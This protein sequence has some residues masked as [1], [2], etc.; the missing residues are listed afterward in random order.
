MV[1]VPAGNLGNAALNLI[2]GND[3]R[4]QMADLEDTL[5]ARQRVAA[6]MD[7]NGNIL[8]SPAPGTPP[9]VGSGQITGAPQDPTA[10][11]AEMQKNGILSPGQTPNAYKSDPSMGSLILAFQ[12]RQ[13]AA[14]GL[15]QS[16][17]LGASAFARP[18]NRERVFRSFAPQAPQDAAKLGE[19]LL[20]MSNAQQG[21]DR[22]SALG[23]M[24]MDPQRGPA[25]AQQL[26][27]GWEELKARY[28]ADPGGV[29]TMIQSYLTPTGDLQNLQGL[30]R[31]G[32]GGA[33]GDKSLDDAAA[34][35]E[36][37]IG[38]QPDMTMAQRNWRN[39]PKNA[40]K[41]DSAMPWR[42]NDPASF[43]QY[44]ADEKV[45][46]G[47]RLAASNE[48]VDK[49]ETTMRL[50]SDLETLKD[51]PG[52][53]SIF[54]T[55]G[56]RAVAQKVLNDPNLNDTST[57]LAA[58]LGLTNPQADALALL[59]RVGGAVTES[60]MKGM[61]GT[62]TR[63]TQMEVGPLKD[64]ITTTQNLGQSY[65]SYIHGAINSAITRAKR[66]VAANFGN[67]GN[68]SNMPPEY[69]PWLHTAFKKGGQLYKDDS[70][71]D[72]LPAAGPVP[73]QEITDGKQLLVDKPYLRDEM[74]DNWQQ[75]GFDTTKL[76]S[77]N[78]SKW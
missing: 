25:I 58:N 76:R 5:Q 63:V 38:G 68:L 32:A 55:P 9:G 45:K 1:A 51:S 62:G 30:R 12:A 52:L 27:I 48:L 13:E 50:Q 53:E 29:G 39:D 65:E 18:E 4:Q 2:W 67:T 7:L 73:Q 23:Q 6:G 66:A 69:A 42:V 56:M 28:Q 20:A 16:I 47:D 71:V 31:M 8:P 40:G 72:T 77:S 37:K 19:S 33:S 21:Q 41:P 24:V 49:N 22:M 59:K 70:G 11:M 61:A 60:A 3:P 35:I 43:A 10:A 36:G 74:L 44:T 14:A 17:G 78:P 26:N 64:A 15:Q 54:K 34:S 57:I 46:S 75:R